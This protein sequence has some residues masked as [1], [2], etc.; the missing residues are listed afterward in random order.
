LSKHTDI[1]DEYHAL[2]AR[3][4]VSLHDFLEEEFDALAL[5]IHAF[6]R[7]QNAPFARWCDTLPEPKTWR[8][9]PA[10]PQ[11]MFKRF[12]LSCFPAKLTRHDG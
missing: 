8:E 12:R 9:V 10:V 7:R 4:F 2:E 6:Q 3:V 11:A 1:L 5:D